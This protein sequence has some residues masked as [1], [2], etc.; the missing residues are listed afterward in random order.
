MLGLIF[1]VR[2]MAWKLEDWEPTIEE[3]IE[4]VNQADQL[5]AVRRILS[6]WRTRLEKGPTLLQPFQIDMIVRE[7]QRRLK[8]RDK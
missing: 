2:P 4:E 3:I 8:G 7:V 5:G 6:N 1:R